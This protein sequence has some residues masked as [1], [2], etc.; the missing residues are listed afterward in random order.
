[1]HIAQ[2]GNV[3]FPLLQISAF[4][5]KTISFCDQFIFIFQ[6]EGTHATRQYTNNIINKVKMYKW[7]NTFADIFCSHK[8]PKALN[9]PHNHP[10][11][12]HQ[13]TSSL[14]SKNKLMNFVI[15]ISN[16]KC[17]KCINKSIGNYLKCVEMMMSITKRVNKNN[18]F[19]FKMTDRQLG[20]MANI[21]S[22]NR[23][24]H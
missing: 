22:I 14:P 2:K 15:I 24:L 10:I 18:I 17:A 6:V 12:P 1:M 16:Q 11:G 5:P 7:L 8:P 21:N 3:E 9:N 19:T 20:H 13:Y 4:I 23:S